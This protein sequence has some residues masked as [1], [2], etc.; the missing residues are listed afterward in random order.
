MC[1]RFEIHSAVEIIAEIFGISDWDI[2]SP[3]RYNIAPGQDILIVIND[4]KRRL[5][6]SRWGFVP[7]W[8]RDLETGYRMINAR[9]ETVASSKTFKSAFEKQRCLVIAD[10]FY[11]WRKEGAAKKP[12]YIR[13]KSQRPFGFAGLYNVWKSPD[14]EP[15][16]TCTIITIDANDLV[17]PIHDRMPVIAPADKYDLRLDPGARDSSVFTAVLNPYPPGEMEL[18]PVTPKVNSLR[19]NSPESIKPLDEL[20]Q[21]AFQNP[22]DAL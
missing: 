21:D 9:A 19:Y 16:T 8:S 10:G 1:G 22:S 4:G 2:E 11:E 12:F 7:S 5:V 18:F 15:L 13:L 17:M 14:G 3:P 20:E 6:K